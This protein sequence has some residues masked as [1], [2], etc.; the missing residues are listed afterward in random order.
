MMETILI[1]SILLQNIKETNTWE[2]N[3]VNI[4]Y[5]SRIIKHVYGMKL[6]IIK[7]KMILLMHIYKDYFK[8]SKLKI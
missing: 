2:S 1:H 4:F 3:I 8:Y 5:A 7:N 6:K